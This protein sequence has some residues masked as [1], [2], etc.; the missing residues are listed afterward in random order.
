MGEGLTIIIDTREQEPWDFSIFDGVSVE[1]GTLAHGDYSLAYPDLRKWVAI[2][3]KTLADFVACCGRERSRFER[4]LWALRGYRWKAVVV[5]ATM[6][7]V[8][9][10]RYRSQIN[11]NS[12]V[13]SIARW[14]GDGIPIVFAETPEGSAWFTCGFLRAIAKDTVAWAKAAC[15]F[16]GTIAAVEKIS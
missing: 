6:G 14:M 16:E 15:V 4:E 13:A 1:S 11:P 5:E 3:R 2:E 10:K 9:N 12:V 7:D 8:F